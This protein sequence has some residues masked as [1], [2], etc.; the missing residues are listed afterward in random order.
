MDWLIREAI[1]LEIHTHNMNREDGL[2]LSKSWK[3]LLHKL[4]PLTAKLNTICHFL[5]LLEV[6]LIFHVSGIRVKE[7]DNHLQHNSFDL[8]SLGPP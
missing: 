1:E 7:R 6:H 4:N 8:A 5:V 3:P 2:T